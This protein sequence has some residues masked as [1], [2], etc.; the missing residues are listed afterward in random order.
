[1]AE[2]SESRDPALTA[3][4]RD[5][6]GGI[7]ASN[8]DLIATSLDAVPTLKESV[9]GLAGT[10]ARFAPAAENPRTRISTAYVPRSVEDGLRIRFDVFRDKPR[11]SPQLGGMVLAVSTP[12]FQKQ[13]LV[14]NDD[15]LRLVRQRDAN[16]TP[17]WQRTIIRPG[18]FQWRPE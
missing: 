3:Y 18:T 17:G 7:T 2:V 10:L 15:G 16:V 12:D 14:F 5:M 9:D 11:F 4:T 1:M 8:Y 6:I 13:L